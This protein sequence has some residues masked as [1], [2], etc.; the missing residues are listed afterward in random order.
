[1]SNLGT[2]VTARRR[3]SP[4]RHREVG[5]IGIVDE[6]SKLRSAIVHDASNAI[7]I[8]NEDQ[9]RLISAEILAEHPETGPSSKH[10]LRQQHT[11]FRDVLIRS[12]V[13]ILSPITEPGA[14]CQVFT[15]DPA[16]AIGNTLFVGSLRDA[17][18]KPETAGLTALRARFSKVVDLSRNDASIEGGDVIV[19]DGARRV[20]VGMNHHTND[21]GYDNLSD[22][23]AKSRIQAIKIAHRALHLDCCLAP[24]PDGDALIAV[25]KLPARSLDILRHQFQRLIPLDADEAALSLAANIFWVDAQTVVSGVRTPKTN[26]LLR[27]KGYGVVEL[28]FSELISLW[29]SFR[30]VVC[31]VERLNLI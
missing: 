22:A 23:L 17:Y 7:D 20:L 2:L 24:L 27:R 16:F 21:A 29:G 13:N 12:G 19:L 30:C 1:M 18:R 31:P 6:F 10:K 8:T 26:Q 14:F 15:R 5:A 3:E 25:Q 9:R 4:I 11:T 28:D